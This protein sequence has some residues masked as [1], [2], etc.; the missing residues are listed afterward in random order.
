MC[1]YLQCVG[2][3]V[4]QLGMEVE[5]RWLGKA[6]L[7]QAAPVC[8]EHREAQ[9]VCMTEIISGSLPKDFVLQ[10]SLTNLSSD[11]AATTCRQW[12]GT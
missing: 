8:A 3:W 4:Q 9:Q 6:A 11:E 1:S 10:L 5:E 12:Q 7:V 2:G